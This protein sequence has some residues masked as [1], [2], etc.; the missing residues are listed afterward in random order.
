MLNLASDL[1]EGEDEMP[2]RGRELA[3]ESADSTVM[4]KIK[5]THKVYT[6]FK[7]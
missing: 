1:A 5:N 3:E 2:V 7:N 6:L 4:E